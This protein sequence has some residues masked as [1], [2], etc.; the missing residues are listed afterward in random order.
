MFSRAYLGWRVHLREVDSLPSAF[1][2]Q[3]AHA[4]HNSSRV[5]PI[6]RHEYRAEGKGVGGQ[7][8]TRRSSVSPRGACRAGDTLVWTCVLLRPIVARV[9]K[10]F[11]PM[12]IPDPRGGDIARRRLSSMNIEK[13]EYRTGC[14]SRG[15][16][17]LVE[18]HY[19]CS[20]IL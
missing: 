12:N 5:L 11:E 15:R 18:E 17:A 20:S 13:R 6:K 19:S 9:I 10:I 3:S 1:L 4:R 8:G 14:L 16:I 7:G 2:K